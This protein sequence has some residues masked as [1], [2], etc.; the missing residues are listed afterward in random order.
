M[1]KLCKYWKKNLLLNYMLMFI[2]FECMVF[3][4]FYLL[5]ICVVDVG[6]NVVIWFV[7]FGIFESF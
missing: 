2:F 3:S 5:G 6:N 7:Y 4:F 1:L